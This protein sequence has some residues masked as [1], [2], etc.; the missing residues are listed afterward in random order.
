MARESRSR[1]APPPVQVRPSPTPFADRDTFKLHAGCSECGAPVEFGEE[2]QS[3]TCG[4]CG[5]VL[6]LELA[7]REVC[8]YLPTRLDDPDHLRATLAQAAA[9]KVRPEIVRRYSD[10]H[11]QL[12]VPSMLIDGK[13][14]RLEERY[15]KTLEVQQSEILWAPYRLCVGELG[16]AF[17]GRKEMGAKDVSFRVFAL[18]YTLRGYPS[19]GFN[20]RD[21]GLKLDLGRLELLTR[22]I[23]ARLPGRFLCADRTAPPPR[24]RARRLLKQAQDKSLVPIVPPRAE[25]LFIRQMIVFKPFVVA[26]YHCDGAA[27]TLLVDGSTE[28]VA[29]HP[30]WSEIEQLRSPHLFGPPLEEAGEA[31]I[32]AFGSECPVCGNDQ[33]FD[34]RARIQLC[35][36]CNRA[37]SVGADGIH[38]APYRW[39]DP[40][41]TLGSPRRGTGRSHVWVPFWRFR[42]RLATA[43]G[44]SLGDLAE[45]LAAIHPRGEIESRAGAH[46]AIPA[47]RCLAHRTLDQAFARLTW[48]ATHRAPERQ[49]TGPMAPD[50]KGL[51]LHVTLDQ[52]EARQ[53]APLVLYTLLD[54]PRRARI[55]MP[56]T[57]TLLAESSLELTEP[58]L[59]YVPY[60][61]VDERVEVGEHAIGMALLERDP[62]ELDL[63]ERIRHSIKLA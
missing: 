62:A 40:P 23:A 18:E 56:T 20:L 53:V 7:G 34:R 47:L 28:H 24:E 41:A 9:Q 51:R 60:P 63:R 36:V 12:M 39:A 6:V 13:V 50:T 31:T 3:T 38:D 32:H 57:R 29:G 43:D 55:N 11:G 10:E 46:L 26:S 35:S 58:E 21:R 59:L 17:V 1:Y 30:D 44:R 4:Y 42:F 45:L 8:F 33:Q 48:D 22:A 16:Q 5:S 25:L 15:L 27:R 54:R 19:G 2:D 14:K 52:D 61:R 37:L 49:F